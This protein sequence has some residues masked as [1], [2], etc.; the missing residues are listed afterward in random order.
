M[1]ANVITYREKSA[2]REVGKVL[3]LARRSCRTG[4][5]SLRPSW[6][7]LDPGRRRS[8]RTWPRPAATRRH[9]RMQLFARAVDEIAGPAAP[10]RPA[11][12][13]HGD[14]RRPARRRGAAGAGHHARPRRHPV[15]QGRLRGPRHHQGR[16]AGPGHDGG[17]AGLAR[18]DRA[19]RGAE[20]D[21]AHLP[22]DDPEVYAML[23]QADTVGVFQVESRAQMATLPRIKPAHFYDLVVEVAIIRP[24]PIVG[25]MVHPY[26]RRRAGREPVD[27]R[28]SQPGAHPERAPSACRSSRSSSCAWP[29]PAAGFTRRRGRGAAP[30][31]GLQALAS[32]AWRRSR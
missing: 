3:G 21:L 1:T 4:W 5:P 11:L 18:P 19:R 22:A 25:N 23:Q 9:P 24:G 17:P 27:L 29:W 15:G 8:P 2:A 26:L 10:P 6:G 30:G 12:G 32:A 13:R 7:Y 14:R 28:A 31:H 20:V 16:P